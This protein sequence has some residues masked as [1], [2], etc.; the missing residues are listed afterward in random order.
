[1]RVWG[2]AALLAITIFLVTRM[3]LLVH[4]AVFSH[5]AIGG[6][7]GALL[8]GLLRDL[9][10][11]AVIA[12][13]WLIFELL[14]SAGWSGRLRLP[15]FIVYV[16]TL[17]FVAVSE[18][19]FW[20]EFGVRFNFIALDYL[21][22]TTEVIGNI[23]ESYP[24]SLILAALGALTAFIVW[25]MRRALGRSA[26][27]EV[28][29]RRQFGWGLGLLL[30]A[31]L[32][33]YQM[34]TPE[35]SAN[36]YAN[37]LA[38]NGW[39]SFIAAARQNRLDYRQF[40]ATRPDAEVMHDLRRL[41]GKD[42]LTA[43]HQPVRRASRKLPQQPN[44]VVIMME[45]MS[46]EY[47]AAFG[48]SEKLTPNLDRLASEGLLFTRLYATGTRTVRG[49]EA[50]SAAL[51]PQAG[52]SVVRWPN[53]TNLNTLGGT[54]EM[55]GWSPQFIYG[56]YGMFDNMNGYFAAQGYKVTD[57]TSFAEGLVQFEN[58]WGVADEHLFDQ[59][60]SELDKA[61]AAGHH[62]FAH[63][64][65][66]SNHRPFTYPDGRIDIPSPG[67]RAGG[68][69]YA[70]YAIGRFMEMAHRKPWF[71]NTIFVFVAD[72]C[73]NSAGKSKIPVDRY[74]I[75]AIIH[76]PKIVSPRQVDTLASQID[77]APTLLAMLGLKD[78]SHFVGRDILSM[79]AGEGRA[80]LSTYQNLGY[81]KGDVL[82][83][84]QPKRR[85]ESFKISANGRDETP[86]A[87]DPELASEAIAYF[88][89]ASI[90]MAR[91][92]DAGRSAN[93]VNDM[94]GQLSAVR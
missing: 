74:R 27:V 34:A 38:D 49:L 94:A 22:F 48:N 82:T 15:L 6:L 40:Y 4:A 50:L 89:G 39:R 1:M 24:V 54:L 9:P 64:M 8:L 70:D 83:V 25:N 79:P 52:M 31:C 71:D 93:K 90:L 76:A 35:F 78:E 3:V 86:I 29:R 42:Q 43:T 13:P 11:A 33:L 73:A 51:P 26:V 14:F 84:L 2:L 66:T 69:K 60:L 21:M 68:V 61:A 57:R 88:Q 20:D 91:H 41:A 5:E 18:G 67:K 87:T 58:V 46:A 65:T 63:V 55:N 53:V 12:S 81:L 32:A 16:F 45:S 19:L 36:A 37:E 7:I 62:F 44:I 59:T 77:L 10:L 23:R 75:P 30:L 28:P 72:H 85:I 80:F 47:M 17:L 92:G 56:G